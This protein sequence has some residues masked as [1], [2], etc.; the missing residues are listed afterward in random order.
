MSKEVYYIQKRLRALG[1]LLAA[2]EEADIHLSNWRSRKEEH[3]SLLRRLYE[4]EK[5]SW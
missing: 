4:L 5:R 1:S 2:E 3:D